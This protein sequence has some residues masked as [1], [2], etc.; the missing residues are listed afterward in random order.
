MCVS[1]CS[2]WGN[3]EELNAE[4]ASYLKQHPEIRALVSDFL[5]FLL[6][7]KPE[8]VLQFSRDYF[9]PFSSRNLLEPDREGSSPW[10]DT[11]E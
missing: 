9:L 10:K 5:Q 6:L 3:K 11:K 2:P 4:H 7:R 8:N 1:M